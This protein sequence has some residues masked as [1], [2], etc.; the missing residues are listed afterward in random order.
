[1]IKTA[2][3]GGSVTP[4]ML[5]VLKQ[6]ITRKRLSILTHTQIISKNFDPVSKT[7]KLETN[8]PIPDLPAIDYIYLATGSGTNA[9]ELPL[10]AS[11]NRDYPIEVKQGFPCI[12]EDLMWKQDVPLFITGRLAALR[13]GPGGPNLEGARLGAERIS[14]ALETVLERREEESEEPSHLSFCGLGNRYAGLD[15]S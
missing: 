8:P 11:M 15:H 6:H 10:L 4:R 5:K 13:L 9:A 14:W 2:R 12:T 7:W 3:N 1:M